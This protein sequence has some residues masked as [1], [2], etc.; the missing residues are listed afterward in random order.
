MSSTSPLSLKQNKP[1]TSMKFDSPVH[2][3]HVYWKDYLSIGDSAID[4]T[5]GNG[6]DT[7][8]IAKNILSVDQGKIYSLDIQTQALAQTRD[9]LCQNLSP[10]ILKRVELI[11]SCHSCFPQE[12]RPKT[13]KLI[14]YNLGYLPGGNKEITTSFETTLSSI[15][16]AMDLV[17]DNGLI[18]I[19]CYP[20]HAAGKIEQTK[21][22]KLVEDLHPWKWICCHHVWINR[23]EAP[24]L[25]LLQ[26]KI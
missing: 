7:L 18:S 19:T 12:I 6:H 16:K 14:V 4:A 5:C 20:G 9:H 2:L 10:E 25:F 8:F 15:E 22:L 17:A 11:Q 21:I 23:N 24:S 26:R 3:A 13:I 1:T